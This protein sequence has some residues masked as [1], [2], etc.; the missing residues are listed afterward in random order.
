MGLDWQLYGWIRFRAEHDKAGSEK[1][2][3]ITEKA[4]RVL[5]ETDFGCSTASGSFPRNGGP[6][7]PSTAPTMDRRL[8]AA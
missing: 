8:K 6:V 3:P 2:V 7:I 5:A 1:W 4:R